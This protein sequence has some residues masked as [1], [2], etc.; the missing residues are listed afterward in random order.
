MEQLVVEAFAAT[1]VDTRIEDRRSGARSTVEAYQGGRHVIGGELLR[2]RWPRVADE[3]E[4]LVA[5]GARAA[6][7]AKVVPEAE[8][9]DL[10]AAIRDAPGGVT[11][12]AAECGSGKT[13]AAVAVAVERAAKSGRLGR[14]TSISVDSHALARQVAADVEKAGASVKRLY[15]ALSGEGGTCAMADVATPLVLGGQSVQWELC[16]GRGKK[17]ERCP[18][19]AG[20]TAREGYIGDGGAAVTVGVHSLLGALDGEAGA[21]GLLVIDEPPSLIETTVLTL[22]ALEHARR[23]LDDFEPPYAEAMRGVV[24][25]AIRWVEGDEPI[26]PR[27]GDEKWPPLRWVTRC[28]AIRDAKT[29]GLVGEASRVLDALGRATAL[30]LGVGAA[31]GALVASSPNAALVKALA[32]EGRAVV[33]DAGA[34]VHLPLYTR[35]LDGPP[36]FVEVAR[37]DGGEVERVILRQRASRTLFLEKGSVTLEGRRAALRAASW[38]RERAGGGQWGF[39]SWKALSVA[40]RS[41]LE[42][43][44]ARVGWYGAMRG[45]ND[46]EDLDV[47]VTVGDPRVS[48]FHVDV[49][50]AYGGDDAGS[51]TVALARAELEQAHGR[52][53][54]VRR[55]RPAYAAH[56][57]EIWPG[58]WGWRADLV[59]VVVILG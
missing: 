37:A 4:R 48:G 49:E 13:R 56:L 57:G 35:V 23:W 51:R 53:R 50:A 15:G 28:R 58:G 3:V 54:V 18:H 7:G 34:R 21:T 2:R 26:P 16:E 25:G 10:E 27:G 31:A 19:Y 45:R 14:K 30:S 42:A 22:E 8:L 12:I 9:V 24:L 47:L 20:C 40:L 17:H 38:A 55:T 11:V 32:R 59:S 1:G 36:H 41:E 43:L 6:A 29:A 5:E 33:T 39:V 46:W 44:G 52:L